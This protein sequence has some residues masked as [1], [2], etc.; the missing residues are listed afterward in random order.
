MDT[1]VLLDWSISRH[2]RNSD[3]LWALLKKDDEL[4]SYEN[5]LLF[6]YRDGDITGVEE[7]DFSTDRLSARDSILT[8]SPSVSDGQ[9]SYGSFCE[10]N[11]TCPGFV[12]TLRP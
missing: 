2:S 12:R 8:F 5:G 1:D 10:G 6:H 9:W 4:L 3:N 7:A 11:H